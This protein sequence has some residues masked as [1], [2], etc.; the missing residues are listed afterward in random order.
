MHYRS[1]DDLTGTGILRHESG[2]SLYSLAAMILMFQ[3][4]NMQIAQAQFIPLPPPA[5]DSQP[6][7]SK[8]VGKYDSV[9]PVI[10]FITTSLKDGKNVI[11]VRVMDDAPI[12]YVLIK[13]ANNHKVLSDKMLA[14]PNN[15]YKSLINVESPSKVVVIKAFDINGNSSEAVM[16]FDVQNSSGLVD[17]IQNFFH[18]IF[19]SIR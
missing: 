11:K 10:Q 19:P 9:P 1:T 8:K 3:F 15:I 6:A 18:G 7:Q 14:D 13:E 5:P 4:F 16:K 17:S 2:L 12:D